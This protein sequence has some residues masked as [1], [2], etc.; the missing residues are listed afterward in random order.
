MKIAISIF[1]T[2]LVLSSCKP[3]PTYNPFDSVFNI[4]VNELV[5]NNCDTISAGCGYFNLSKNFGE[6]SVFYQINIE[7]PSVVLAKGL[8]LHVDTITTSKR[9]NDY[10]QSIDDLFENQ[11]IDTLRIDLFLKRFQLRRN[12]AR[13]QDEYSKHDL[14]YQNT[15][16]NQFRFERIIELDSN[17][18]RAIRTYELFISAPQEK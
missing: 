6:Y 10:V 2:L 14:I 12:S 3:E 16:G 15:S 11:P 5:E 9:K 8:T 18:L 7:A 17:E 13:E 4:D 1:S